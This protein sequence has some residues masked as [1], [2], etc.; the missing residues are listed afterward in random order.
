MIANPGSMTPTNLPPVNEDPA[1][2]RVLQ[3]E[4]IPAQKRQEL[5]HILAGMLVKQI[6]QQPTGV[7]HERPA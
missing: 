5:T 2:N 3:W 4:Q 7:Q 6:R 1:T